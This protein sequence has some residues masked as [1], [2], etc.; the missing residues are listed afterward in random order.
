MRNKWT[1]GFAVGSLLAVL[2]LAGCYEPVNFPEVVS[3]PKLAVTI[4]PAYYRIIGTSVQGYPLVCQVIGEGPDV[5]LILATIHGSEPAGTPLVRRLARHL[6][7][8]PD[9]LDGRTVV[10]L[11]VA[12]PDGMARENRYNAHGVDL[13]RN[14]EAANRITDEHSGRTALSEPEARAIRQLVLDYKPDRIVSLHQPLSCIDYDGPAGP[15]ASRMAE[16]CD[17]PVKKVG[18]RPGS[19]GSYAGVT[20][21]IPII[22]FEMLP[23]DS[24]LDSKALWNRYGKSLVAA[25]IYPDKVETKRQPVRAGQTAG[26]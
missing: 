4:V 15:L 21:G 20:L 16:Y 10:L 5:T 26:K 12:N 1:F 23:A 6:Q 8:N 25:V 7:E 9:L 13:N 24:K 18:A 22:T 11:P 17:L 2:N 3:P 19:L 14:F